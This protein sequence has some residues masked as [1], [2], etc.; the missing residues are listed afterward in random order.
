MVHAM[1][2]SK[3]ELKKLYV[4]D[5]KEVFILG[6]SGELDDVEYYHDSMNVDCLNLIGELC[7]EE[8]RKPPLKCNVLFEYQSTFAVFQFSDIDDDI[9]EYIDFCPFN[10][11]NMGAKSI[12]R[13]RVVSVRLIICLWIISLSLTNQ[14]NMCI[15]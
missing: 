9:K 4:A 15:W 3:E 1:R 12:V 5:A 13:M 6:D 7:K 11:T 10:F 8:N 2:D 14:R